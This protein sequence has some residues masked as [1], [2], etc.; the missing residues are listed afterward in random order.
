MMVVREPSRAQSSVVDF[1]YMGK[2]KGRVGWAAWRRRMTAHSSMEVARSGEAVYV[3]INGPGNMKLC[4]T[5]QDFARRMVK[6]GYTKFIVN[7][8]DCSTMDS[9]FMG[10]LVELASL[11][12][13]GAESLLI[14]NAKD[15]CEGLLEG[16][17]LDNVLQIKRGYTELPDIEL[18]P[19]PEYAVKQAERIRLIKQAHENLVEIDERNREKFGPFLRQLTKEMENMP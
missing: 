6:E 3:R 9:T 7:L 12:K 19:L 13:P 18:E 8:K 4:P 15:H 10:T 17:G 16:L 11:A 14:I 1:V 2:Y 5:L